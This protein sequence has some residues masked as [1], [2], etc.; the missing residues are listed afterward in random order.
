MQIVSVEANNHS[1]NDN[2]LI[3]GEKCFA[4]TVQPSKNTLYTSNR[5][6]SNL[7]YFLMVM[8]NHLTQNFAGIIWLQFAHQTSQLVLTRF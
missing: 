5:I 4:P 1:P 2:G 3:L 6:N 8:L 7:H